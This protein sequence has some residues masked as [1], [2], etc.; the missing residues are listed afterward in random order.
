MGMRLAL[1]VQNLFSIGVGVGIAFYYGWQL[2]LVVLATAPLLA[3]ANA[4]EMA[5]LKGN[6]HHNHFIH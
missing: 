1:M 4:A 2:T 3:F 6:L 5:S